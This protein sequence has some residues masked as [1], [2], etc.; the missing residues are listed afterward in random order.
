MT[1][2][3]RRITE[4]T[5]RLE[6]DDDLLME[7]VALPSFLAIALSCVVLGV[8]LYV[9]GSNFGPYFWSV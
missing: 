3:H 8:D 5:K 9:N 7:M 1:D 4:E 6:I 2:T